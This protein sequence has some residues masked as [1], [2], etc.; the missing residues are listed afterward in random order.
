MNDE[1]GRKLG[2][3]ECTALLIGG[4]IGSAIFSLSGIT[5]YS[6][7][8]ASVISWIAAGFIMLFYG[9][10]MAELAG[11][12]PVSGGVYVFPRMAFGGKTGKILGWLACWS[13]ILTN[14]VAVSFAAIYVSIYLSVSIPAVSGYQIPLAIL[15]ILA[16]VFLN[17]IRFDISGKINTGLVIILILT[18]TVFVISAFFSGK[19][20]AGLLHPFFTQGADGSL[21]FISAVPTAIFGYSSIISIAYLVSD[22]RNPGKT[23]PKSTFISILVVSSVYALIILSTMGLITAGYLAENPD[24]QYI[25]VFAACFTAL[26][27]IPWLATVVSIAAS[28]SLITT[29]SV[30]ISITSRSLQAVSNDGILPPFFGRVTSYGVPAVAAAITGFI[31]ICMVCF[32]ENVSILINFGAIF[33]VISIV[34]TILAVYKARKKETYT[35]SSFKTP[36]GFILP[37]LLILILF[38]C[39]ISGIITGGRNIWIYTGFFLLLGMIIF[40]SGNARAEERSNL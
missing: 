10:L 38:I 27:E 4:M 23:I 3:P 21:G 5:M 33:N 34:I 28:L 40:F 19:Y 1:T 25:P 2:L 18:M 39:N 16:C 8:P 31:T 13:S 35:E 6:A 9:L 37:T 26:S 14:L 11:L 32:P 29:M 15:T 7:G 17:V 12:Y 36:G 22:V 24:M 30:C 20:D